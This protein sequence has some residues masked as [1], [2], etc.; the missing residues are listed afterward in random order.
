MK[1]YIIPI[2]FCCTYLSGQSKETDN[3]FGITI[4]SGVGIEISGEVEVEFIDVEG[5]GGAQYRD[6]FIQKVDYRS[7]FVE[8]DKTVL[9]F[10]LLYTDNLTYNFSLRFD[11]DGAYA[12]KHFLKYQTESSTLEF[13]KN[14]SS[15]NIY[16]ARESILPNKSSA[17]PPY[18]K[19]P[20]YASLL[21]T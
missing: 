19:W 4:P 15:E 21:K 9:D 13:G 1:N 18:Q 11:D 12:D 3:G 10:K 20:T 5:R 2:L 8:I 6:E 17:L 16:S 7:P 14:P